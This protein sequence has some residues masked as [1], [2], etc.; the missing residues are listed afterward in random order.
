MRFPQWLAITFLLGNL[1]A[2]FMTDDVLAQT[3][4]VASVAMHS[5]MGNPVANL[6]RIERC[7]R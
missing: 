2:P 6:D 5:E 7:S 1:H 4:R 3:T